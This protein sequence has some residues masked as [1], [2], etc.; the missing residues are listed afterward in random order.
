MFTWCITERQVPTD[1]ITSI[2]IT[3][4]NGSVYNL[5][6]SDISA[7]VFTL[8]GSWSKQQGLNTL[9]FNVKLTSVSGTVLEFPQT[10]MFLDNVDN[11]RH[12]VCGFSDLARIS[13]AAEFSTLDNVIYTEVPL[14]I[15]IKRPANEA[16]IQRYA[17]VGVMKSFNGRAPWAFTHNNI[18]VLIRMSDVEFN[19]VEYV[20]YRSVRMT[21]SDTFNVSPSYASV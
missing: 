11:Q 6:K 19:G 3:D 18:P 15:P 21:G 1:A 4:P 12:Y 13:S 20:M 5:V 10:I 16:G 7:G 8:S 9:V 2:V 14:N 17:W